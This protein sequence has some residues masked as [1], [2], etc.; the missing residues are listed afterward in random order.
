MSLPRRSARALVWVAVLASLVAC[1]ARPTR[2]PPP[3][4]ALQSAQA[5]REQALEARDRWSLEG[6]VAVRN[7]KDGG[8]GQLRWDVD[9]QHV[10]LSLSAPV[11]GQAWRLQ[12]RPG[13]AR[14]DGLEGG[15]LEAADADRL[16]HEAL[17][18]NIPLAGLSRWV[19]GMR[20]GD[21]ALRFDADGLPAS[22]RVDGWRIEYR[23]WTAHD[24]IPLPRRIDAERGEQRLR[25]VVSAW[26]LG[27]AG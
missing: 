26:R 5:A 2:V 18:W 20:S 25:L 6:R 8:S 27:D 11:G 4:A 15:P 13:A 22:L 3:D 23:G 7:G 24:G 12:A 16:L 17:D 14:L 1:S 10:E 19:R 21:A 9:G